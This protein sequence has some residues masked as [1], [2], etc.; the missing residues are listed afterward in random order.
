MWCWL[1][2]V[3][4]EHRQSPLLNPPPTPPRKGGWTW[5]KQVGQPLEPPLPRIHNLPISLHSPGAARGAA[6]D[7]CAHPPPRR[8]PS[9]SPP[10]LGTASE[11]PHHT[12]RRGLPAPPPLPPQ[13]PLAR[14][15]LRVPASPA[16]PTLAP[17]GPGGW[18]GP[19]GR[20]GAGPGALGRAGSPC[21]RRGHAHHAVLPVPVGA[22]GS[23][24][25]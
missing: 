4:L 12:P 8:C 21:Q 25:G 6:I 10:A 24:A 13:P 7:P 1:V 17:P 2:N 23:P 11:A 20:G 9:P 14:V 19:S 18:R 5:L 16:V 15:T 3:G 22:L